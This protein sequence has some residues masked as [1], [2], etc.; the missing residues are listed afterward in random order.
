MAYLSAADLKSY[1]GIAV[2]TDDTLL[3]QI[4]TRA[5]AMID[6]YTGRT[7]EAA[8]DSTRYLDAIED[9]TDSQTLFLDRDLCAIT[10]ITNGDGVAVGATEYTTR[11]RNNTPYY[12]IVLKNS[13]NKFWTYDQDPD[14]AITIVGKWAYSATAPADI[15]QAMVRLASYIYRQKDNAGDLD[16]PVIVGNNTTLLPAQLPKDIEMILRPYVRRV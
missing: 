5:Q 4:L 8:A 1:L 12:E 11:P 6:T 7:F 2:T 10:S 9:V 16:R 14:K 13:S 3:G 15:V